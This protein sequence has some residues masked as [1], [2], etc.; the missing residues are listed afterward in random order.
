MPTL[1][2]VV[3]TTAEWA[4]Q[5][6]LPIGTFNE[7]ESTQDIAKAAV[8]NVDD[9]FV[10]YLAQHQTAGRGRG[11]NTFLDT[12]AGE[13]LL[14]S[15]SLELPAAPQAITGP[16]IGLA[17]FNAARETWPSLAWGLKAPNDLQLQGQ[18]V[19]GLLIEAIST[20]AEHRLII[21][22]GMN[23]LN[24]PRSLAEATHLTAA[25]NHSLEEG[26]WYQFLDALIDQ[27]S[28][29]VKDI[30]QPQLSELA[31][32]QLA[33]ALN[34]GKGQSI[35]KVTPQ[36]DLIHSGGRTRWEDL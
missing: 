24:H 33:D 34:A 5:R 30:V 1:T 2:S 31:C 35:Q 15:W 26:E 28:Q 17:L 12:G 29:S 9:P 11:R 4:L 36:G 27:L 20:A 32:D 23:I 8:A 10:L 7:V 3:D 25:L 19:A 13:C 21:G 16:R 22:L 6:K 18:K 14:S